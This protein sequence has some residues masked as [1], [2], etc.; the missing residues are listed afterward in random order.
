MDNATRQR[1][2]ESV[3]HCERNYRYYDSLR[4]SNGWWA[5]L[6]RGGMLIALI[7]AGFA[8]ASVGDWSDWR[9]LTGVALALIGV[10]VSIAGFIWDFA[11]KAVLS[12]VTAGQFSMLGNEWKRILR[13]GDEGTMTPEC[14]REQAVLL[15]KLQ[16]AVGGYAEECG[17]SNYKRNEKTTE[18]A[19]EYLKKEF[20]I[21]Q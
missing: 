20:N 18:E 7:G 19:Y 6:V 1:I 15:E 5:T 21:A 8:L 4:A 12:R 14:V 11:D 13:D 9:V 17:W 3:L 10:I 16:V 2:W